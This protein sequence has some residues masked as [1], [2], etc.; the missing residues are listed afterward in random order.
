MDEFYKVVSVSP[1]HHGLERHRVVDGEGNIR[2]LRIA[3]NILNNVTDSRQG[4]DIKFGDW[5]RG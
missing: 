5:A 3:A 2:K 4:V 1:F